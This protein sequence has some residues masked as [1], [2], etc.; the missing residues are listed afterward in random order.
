[1]PTSLE[2]AY[3][4][5]LGQILFI[6]TALIIGMSSL[7]NGML[8][9]QD[10]EYSNFFGLLFVS[11]VCIYLFVNILM[12]WI[13]TKESISKLNH[14]NLKLFSVDILIICVFFVI[15][16]VVFFMLGSSMEPE[17]INKT[18]AKVLSEGWQQYS[19]Y[20][21]IVY[22]FSFLHLLLTKIWNNSFYKLNAPNSPIPAYESVFSLTIYIMAIV[23][24]MSVIFQGDFKVQLML[25]F[26]WLATFIYIDVSWIK[27][28]IMSKHGEA[29]YDENELSAYNK[30]I[31]QDC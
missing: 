10:L 27:A 31:K 29:S 30:P 28:E 19:V 15:N 7:F 24:I 5:I 16:N 18:L 9:I 26:F 4:L 14:Y 21:S 1:M 6:G 8:T 17:S 2:N 12:C 23:L 22:M 13:A 3:L 11:S 25:W 20:F